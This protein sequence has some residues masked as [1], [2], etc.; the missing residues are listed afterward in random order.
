LR[1]QTRP[2]VD[3]PG[4]DLAEKR[5]R[6]A[7]SGYNAQI[8]AARAATV[9]MLRATLDADQFA[10]L[11]AWVEAA[12]QTEV[13]RVALADAP[14]AT[15][16]TG[17]PSLRVFATWFN[18]NAGD[19]LDEVALPDK[20]L[21]FANRGL[22][23]FLP[24]TGYEGSDY[25]VTVTYKNK[26]APSLRVY[27]VGPW[28]TDDTYWSWGAGD[29]QPR[30]LFTDLPSGIP[31]AQAAFLNGYNGGKDQF[32]RTVTNAAALDVGPAVRDALSAPGA[33][34]G[35][36]WVQLDLLWRPTCRHFLPR[37]FK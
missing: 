25:R 36:D 12:W 32:G 16:C 24:P 22:R 10:A 31:E 13:A 7:E 18:P 29:P 5:R 30:R 21:K 37:L 34:F 35:A 28:N 1:E 20:Y 17:Y 19:P 8:E 26:T 2:L 3:D 14:A 27:E 6:I 23:S 11:A 15:V 9:A 4:I 33:A